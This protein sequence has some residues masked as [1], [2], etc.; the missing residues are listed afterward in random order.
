LVDV[1][2]VEDDAEIRDVLR[3]LLKLDGRFRVMAEAADGATGIAALVDH[4]PAVVI[5]D[6]ELPVLSGVEVIRAARAKFPETRV[7]VFSCYPDPLTLIEVLRL[8]AD[9]Y[10]DKA[11]AWTD[12]IPT[13]AG[14]CGLPDTRHPAD[15]AT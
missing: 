3:L 11:T 10:L 6:L 14:L 7:V 13:I 9:S 2:I 15:A 12:L 4:E 5:V 8:G 1:V